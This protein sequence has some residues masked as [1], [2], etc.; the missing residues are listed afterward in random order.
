MAQSA[1]PRSGAKGW[2]FL[3]L[4]VVVVLNAGGSHPEIEFTTASGSRSPIRREG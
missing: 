2:L 4:G 3:V 1:A